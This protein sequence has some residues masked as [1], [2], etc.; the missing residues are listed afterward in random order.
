MVAEPECPF[1]AEVQGTTRGEAGLEVAL[2]P[3]ASVCHPAEADP[4]AGSPPGR[5]G[6]APPRHPAGAA[7]AGADA[8][9]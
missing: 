7:V 4:V 9:G 3:Q 2:A 6:A 5:E 8:S 1:V